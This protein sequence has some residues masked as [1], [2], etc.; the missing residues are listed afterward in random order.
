MSSFWIWHYFSIKPQISNLRNEI[1]N[2]KSFQILKGRP[3]RVYFVIGTLTI[4]QISI[5]TAFRAQT[6]T[7]VITK[8]L[9]RH[10]KQQLLTHYLN[11]VDL[12][13]DYKRFV[14]R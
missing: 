11:Q 1:W 2:L 5:R 9:F 4:Y 14:D 7:I 6:F 3:A 13:A 8:D 12:A 10:R